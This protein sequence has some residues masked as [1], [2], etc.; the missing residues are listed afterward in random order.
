MYGVCQIVSQSRGRIW[1]RLFSPA[2]E[3]RVSLSSF[4]VL[5]LWHTKGTY[6]IHTWM[7]LCLPIL[8]CCKEWLKYGWSTSHQNCFPPGS[9]V[10]FNLFASLAFTVPLGGPRPLRRAV[11]HS[12]EQSQ[13][14]GGHAGRSQCFTPGNKVC[15][16]V[17]PPRCHLLL[18]QPEGG[19]GITQLAGEW[20]WAWSPVRPA[21]HDQACYQQT[22]PGIPGRRHATSISTRFLRFSIP[23]TWLDEYCLGFFFSVW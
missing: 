2:T 22:L 11:A 9:L 13:H 20:L 15:L 7:L 14:D 21:V 18:P 8:P 3:L 16:A 4:Y 19:T 23:K 10:P 1:T 6:T 12:W 5:Q 17:V